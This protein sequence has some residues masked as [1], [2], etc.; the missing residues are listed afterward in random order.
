MAIYLTNNQPYQ[1]QQPRQQ[2]QN[3]NPMQ[4]YKFIQ[5]LFSDPSAGGNA[6]MGGQLSPVGASGGSG[7]GAGAG[8]LGAG[9]IMA[10]IAAAI[11]AQA[12][13][14]HNTDTV[15]EGQK[16]NDA[17]SGN[18]GTEPWFAFLADK[19]GWEPTAGEKFDAAVNN[20]DWSLAAKRFPAM[21]NYW[22]DPAQS[23]LTTGARE[24]LGNDIDML[25]DPASYITR[26]IE[27]WF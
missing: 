26:K 27:D 7:G 23:W 19:M 9:G 22:R 5:G 24:Y 4:A 16:T 18:F 1:T 14:S 2:Q 15:F 3:V 8:G 13:A 6:G 12:A 20:E 21:T 11:A 25:I 10:I 17:F